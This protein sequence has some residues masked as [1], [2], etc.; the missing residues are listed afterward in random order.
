MMTNDGSQR[1]WVGTSIHNCVW[2]AMIVLSVVILF[3]KLDQN[4]LVDFGASWSAARLLCRG[5]N[6]YNNRALLENERSAGWSMAEAVVPWN[7]PWAL[8][9]MIP[10]AL[11]PFSFA[12]WVWIVINGLLILILADYWW[13]A[14]GGSREQRMASWLASVWYFPC[15]VALYFG[16]MSLFVLAGVTGMAWSLRRRKMEWLGFFILLASLKPH[17][18]FPMWLFLIFWIARQKRW[19]ILIRAGSG[20]L[21]ACIV[22]ACLRPGIYHDY[23]LAATS[24]HSPAIWATPTIGTLLRVEFS[25]IPKWIIFLPGICGVLL[26]ML[27]WKKWRENF[28]WDLHLDP[29]LLLS[30]ATASY[31]W[32]FDWAILLPCLIRI[33]VWFQHRPAKQ[34]ASILGLVFIMFAF[35]WAQARGLFPLGAAWFPWGLALVYGWARWRQDRLDSSCV[36]SQ[37]ARLP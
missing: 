11:L 3:P 25:D 10:L 16:Q 12:K 36:K 6:S 27:L 2:A 22:V 30:L 5:E 34:W 8:A 7:P 1:E 15:I 28:S 4:A 29:I 31:A 20:I 17:L 26:S 24:V 23:A 32:I 21:S 9:I 19:Q 14:Y 35:V 37:I 18:L 33:F 13:N